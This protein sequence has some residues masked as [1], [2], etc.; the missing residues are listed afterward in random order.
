MQS[1]KG[2]A[3]IRFNNYNWD[4]LDCNCYT[5][6]SGG[7]PVLRD[8]RFRRALAYAMTSRSSSRSPRTAMVCRARPSSTPTPGT[9]PTTTGSRRRTRPTPSTSPRPTSYSTRPAI[10]EERRAS[11]QQGKPIVLRLWAKADTD[12]E[13]TE[14]KLIAGWLGQLGLKIDFSVID[15]GAMAARVWNYQGKT[16]DPQFDLYVS[17]W[18]GYTDPG[19]T[20]SAFTTPMIGTIN[21][22]GWSNAQYDKLAL[23]QE[24]TLD[25]QARKDLVW[26]MQQIMY[27]QAPW[28]VLTY[29][30]LLEAYNTQRW[31]GWTRSLNG[32]GPAVVYC[33]GSIASY[34]T[35]DREC[36]GRWRCQHGVDRC[37]HRGCCGCHRRADLACAQT[38]EARGRGVAARGALKPGSRVGMR[39]HVSRLT[40][41][42]PR[43]RGAMRMPQMR[44]I[45]GMNLAYVFFP[46]TYFLDAM[47]DVRNR[48]HRALGR[49]AAPLCDDV[50]DADVAGCARDRAP[51]SRV[52]CYTPEQC[53]YPVNWAADDDGRASRS[54]RYFEAASRSPLSSGLS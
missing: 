23:Q 13:Q 22:T 5:G 46:L 3:A 48:K 20:L 14:A 12:Y 45:A 10:P 51:R 35:F 49:H 53:A 39:L 17:D 32:N 37:N 8:W 16:Y 15:Y 38:T 33:G 25:P 7:N 28:I 4:Y 43:Q 42:H 47:V 6:P 1:V 52:V 21:E 54:L 24:T 34:L 50:S 27:Q 40:D 18:I 29:P 19:P 2:I 9:T 11:Q 41:R 26:Q 36:C 44:Q 31:T 30:Y